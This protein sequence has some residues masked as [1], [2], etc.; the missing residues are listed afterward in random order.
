MATFT[1]FNT[2][3]QFKKFTLTDNELVKR[4]FL[5]SLNIRSGELPGR[6]EYGTAIWDYVFDNQSPELEEQLR[7]EILKIAELDPRINVASIDFFPSNNGVRIEVGIQ[8]VP[9]SAVELL[10]IFFDRETTSARQ[11]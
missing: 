1:G 7:N 6:P 5:N 11:V 9:S 3:G 8:I 2:I 4:D 10:N